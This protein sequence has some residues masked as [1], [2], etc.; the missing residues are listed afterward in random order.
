MFYVLN[1]DDHR[2]T[3]C[4]DVTKAEALISR[5]LSEGCSKDSLEIINGLIDD[6]RL[7][8][9]Q[10][11]NLCMEQGVPIS[12]NLQESQPVFN[13]RLAGIQAFKKN[14]ETIQRA[15]EDEKQRMT[16]A[17]ISEIRTLKPRID[18]LLVTGNACMQ[19]GI[20]LTGKAWGGH[21]GYDT[22]QFITNG[23]S[24]LLG[25]VQ[26][27]DPNTRQYLPFSKLGI[28]GGGACRFNLETDGVKVNVTGD[29]IYILNRFIKEFDSF[30]SE[31]YSYIDQTLA[32]QQKSLDKLI[33]KAEEKALS[34]TSKD[35]PATSRDN[36]S[37]C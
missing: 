10:F 7:N 35:T 5:L 3:S 33:S 28:M 23:W 9:D 21:E 1:F 12:E 25:F 2:F 20:E 24:H 19:S 15:A 31:L 11:W 13:S 18:E 32:K 26:E 29:T 27:R 8:V 14:T 30:E 36:L 17:L 4:D 22:H 34:S 37:R 6:V 16:N